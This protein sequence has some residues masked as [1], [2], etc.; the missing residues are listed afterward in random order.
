MAT[1]NER[2]EAVTAELSH[3]S[4]MRQTPYGTFPTKGGDGGDD[5]LWLGLLSSTKI[6][7][8][9]QGVLASQADGNSHRP[10][11]FYRNPQRRATDN[12]G[13]PAFFSRDMAHGVLLAYLDL[14]KNAALASSQAWLSW[15]DKNRA[16]AV[17]KPKW[18]GG[19][20]MIR[21]P[22]RYAPDSRSDITPTMW[23][24]MGRVWQHMGWKKHSQMVTWNG[25]DGDVSVKEA[26]TVEL[27]YQLHLK[28]VQAYIKLLIGQS[29]EYR[30]RVADIC[31]KRQPNNLFY[32]VLS[33]GRA[34]TSDKEQFL[35]LCPNPLSFS[36]TDHWVWERGIIEVH[37]SCGWDFVFLGRLM[38]MLR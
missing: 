6:Y 1:L 22:Y 12:V 2:I 21:G 23:A 18:M 9:T 15:I 35:A 30:E 19:G 5:C 11:M 10:G 34:T 31:Y 37:K 4:P 13:H 3:R 7:L 36:P 14:Q 24:I 27:G 20:C 8:A 32:K 17:S 25:S 16:C 33:Q 28:A 26:E 38:L 29:R